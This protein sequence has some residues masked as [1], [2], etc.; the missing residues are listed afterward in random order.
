MC[1]SGPVKILTNVVP[2]LEQVE[3]WAEDGLITTL[4]EAARDLGVS[5]KTFMTVLRH[6][7]SGMKV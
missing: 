1:C 6:A 7:L 4:N 3:H 5:Q 2:R